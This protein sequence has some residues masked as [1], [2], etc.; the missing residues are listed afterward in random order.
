MIVLYLH[1]SNVVLYLQ[2][3]LMMLIIGVNNAPAQLVIMMNYIVMAIGILKGAL[4][5]VVVQLVHTGI[6]ALEQ[7]MAH[8]VAVQPVV[9]GDTGL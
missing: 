9:L 7:M 8:A 6:I 2:D 4:L 3:V 5:V 1:K